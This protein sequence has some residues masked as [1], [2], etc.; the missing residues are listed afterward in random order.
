MLPLVRI[1]LADE[2]RGIVRR[3][4]RARRVRE[5]PVAQ[6]REV[7]VPR[8]EPAEQLRVRSPMSIAP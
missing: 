3:E 2:R 1:L 5:R 4:L 6:R 7:P 8:A